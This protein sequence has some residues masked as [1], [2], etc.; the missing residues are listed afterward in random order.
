MNKINGITN[1]QHSGTVVQIVQHLRPGG[2]ETMAL[3]LAT[4]GEARDQTVIISLE[5]DRDTMI[6]SWPRL[7]PLRNRLFFLNKKPGLQVNLFFELRKLLITLQADVVH[8][9]H[10]GPLLYGGSAAR[11]A[12]VRQLIH[13]EHDAW[14]LNDG[15]RRRL[16][17]SLIKLLQPLFVADADTV[18]SNA[19]E[20]MKLENIHVIKNGIDT[21]RFR[22]GCQAAARTNLR[23]PLDVKLVGCSGR[24]EE[25]KGQ[26]VLIEAISTLPADTHLVLAGSGTQRSNLVKQVDAAGLNDRVSFLGHIDDM[27]TFYQALDVFCL[28]SLNEGLPLAP[29]EAQACGIPTVAS[30][31]GGTHEAIC[32]LTGTLVEAANAAQMAAAIQTRL[33]CP[34]A[35]SPRLF[36]KQEGDIQ[37]MLKQYFQLHTMEAA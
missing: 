7:V 17:S 1:D 37:H 25:V 20:K 28:P 30:N 9:H 22:P 27:P 3:D 32:P 29:L 6:E 34:D 31:V 8:T 19:R 12:G 33:T 14:H 23:L 4:L 10:I 35:F 18:A 5:G 13:T 26:H 21:K 15:K 24:L 2:I 36:V 16:Q 11:L